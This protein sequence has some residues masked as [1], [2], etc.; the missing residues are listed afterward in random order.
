MP[1]IVRVHYDDNTHEL[2][3]I[4]AEIWRSNSRQVKKLFITDKQITQVEL[5]PRRETADTETSNNTWPPKMEPSRFKLFKDKKE[6]NPMQKLKATDDEEDKDEE[7]EV[8]ENR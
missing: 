7:V 6:K 5:D 2:L 8:E 3:R 4:P 1:I